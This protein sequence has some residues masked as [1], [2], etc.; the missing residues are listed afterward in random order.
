MLTLFPP[1]NSDLGWCHIPGA[2]LACDPRLE[3]PGPRE[4]GVCGRQCTSKM[5]LEYSSRLQRP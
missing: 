1:G 2:R 3:S 4:L 5:D